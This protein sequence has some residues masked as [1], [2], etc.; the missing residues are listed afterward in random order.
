MASREET[1]VFGDQT[2]HVEVH[3]GIDRSQ[4][5][6]EELQQNKQKNQQRNLN[7]RT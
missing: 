5:H 7:S 6:G 2:I 1:Y 3:P 4:F